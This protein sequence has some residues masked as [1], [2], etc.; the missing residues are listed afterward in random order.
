MFQST[1]LYTDKKNAHLLPG[2]LNQ[3]DSDAMSKS[4]DDMVRVDAVLGSLLL[5]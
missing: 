1:Q 5:G 4:S 2:K 3:P